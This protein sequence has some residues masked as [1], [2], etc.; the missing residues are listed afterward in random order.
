MPQESGKDRARKAWSGSLLRVLG[1]CLLAV[2]ALLVGY[3]IVERTWLAGTDPEVLSTLRFLRALSTAAI[4]AALATILLLGRIQRPAPGEALSSPNHRSWKR[5]VQHVSL[6]TKIVVPMVVLAVTPATAVAVFTISRMQ[7]SL[8]ESAIERV[9][10]ETGSKAR[11]V[12]EFLE[13]VQQDLVFL[14]Q[15]NVVRNLATAES[16]GMTEQIKV[17]RREAEEEFQIFSQGKRAYYQLRYLNNVGHEV[18]RLNVNAGLPW[19]VPVQQLQDK[20]QRYYVK[21]AL[22]VTP[23]EIYISPMDLN[24]EQGEVEVPYRAVV[25]YATPVVGREGHGQGLMAINLS[26]DYL[27]SLV[28]PL[29]SGTEAWLTDQE[30]VYLGYVGESKEQGSLHSL[31]KR[32]RLSADYGPQEMTAILDNNGTV[33]TAGAIVSFAPILLAPEGSDRRWILIISQPSAPIDLP[34]RQLTLFLSVGVVLVVAVAGVLGVLVA[35][36]LAHPVAALR[37]ATREIASGDLSKRVEITTG[38]EIEELAVDFNAMTRRLYT[39]QERLSAWNVELER[40]VRQQTDELHRLQSGLARADKLA[41]VGQITAGVMHEIGNPLAAIKTKIQ[42]AEEEGRLCDNCQALLSEILTEVDRLATFLRSFSR[43]ARLRQPQMQEVSLAEVVQGITALVA[44][45]LEIRGISLSVESKADVPTIRADP[46]QLRQ[47]LINLILNAAEASPDGGEILMK[48]HRM[49]SSAKIEIVDHGVG[50]P[51]EVFQ[52]IWNP[53]FTTK[54]DGTGLGLGICR[55]I[56]QDHKGTIQV[57]SKTGEGTIVTL[58]FPK[59]GA[60]ALQSFRDSV[61]GE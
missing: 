20:S 17:L 1:L 58:T 44:P 24:V 46:D 12:E 33:E 21:D 13:T 30:G 10:F 39:A 29:P 11:A 22:A 3:E 41:S 31:E 9:V 51:P 43:L 4:A 2:T 25:R 40:E 42:V 8:R 38:D 7:E 14:S 37:Q 45:Q 60:D 16:S 53:F 36:Y 27:F 34:I 50:M 23:G 54:P 48:V 47:L 35:H 59:E 61:Q 19:V 56:V 18:V 5:R 52:S 57:R 15:L 26:A 32:R 6:R 49:D 28:G 55:Q